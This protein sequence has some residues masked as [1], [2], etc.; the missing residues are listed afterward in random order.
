MIGLDVEIILPNGSYRMYGK[1][2]K[3][4]KNMFLIKDRN[5][6]IKKFPKNSIIIVTQLD[7]ESV[8]KINGNLMSGRPEE[9]IK[10][11]HKIFFKF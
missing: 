7:D 8:V 6:N 3:E 11:R 1:V 2:Y 4:T 10:K 9:R 5:N